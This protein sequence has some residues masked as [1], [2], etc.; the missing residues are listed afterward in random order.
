MAVVK[1][2]HITERMIANYELRDLTLTYDRAHHEWV[3]VFDNT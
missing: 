1:P 2:F 3:I